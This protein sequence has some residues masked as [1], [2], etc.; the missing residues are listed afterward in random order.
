MFTNGSNPM[1]YL[2][3]KEDTGHEFFKGLLTTVDL[4]E[5]LFLGTFEGIP[6]YS[7]DVLNED[8]D[9]V[10]WVEED[11]VLDCSKYQAHQFLISHVRQIYYG[12][13]VC[14]CKMVLYSYEGGENIVG[15]QTIHPIRAGDELIYWNP[16]D[17]V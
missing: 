3:R 15:L 17:M 12:A 11:C 6:T 8:Y 7:W 5:G 14:N 1:A 2:R 10:I 13:S 9:K 16:N 4:P